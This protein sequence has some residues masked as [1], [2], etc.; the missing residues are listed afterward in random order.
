MTQTA[1]SGQSLEGLVLT[2]LCNYST[3]S[4]HASREAIVAQTADQSGCSTIPLLH[5]TADDTQSVV[6][7][8]LR[9]LDHQLVGAAHH[10]AHRL[11]GAGAACDLW[12]G[13]GQIETALI[14]FQWEMQ[15]DACQSHLRIS[16]SKTFKTILQL[17]FTAKNFNFSIHGGWNTQATCNAYHNTFQGYCH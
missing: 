7:G 12:R 3:S 9:L 17:T 2:F 11:T 15:S 5:Q 4:L 6:D 14:D 16:F 1:T 8:A 13:T 10:D